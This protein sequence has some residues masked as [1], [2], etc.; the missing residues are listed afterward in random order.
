MAPDAEWP[1][2]TRVPYNRRDALIYATGI[3]LG[4]QE[5]ELKFVYELHPDFCIVPTLFVPFIFWAAPGQSSVMDQFKDDIQARVPGLPERIS[6]GQDVHYEQSI[7]FHRPFPVSGTL[8]VQAKTVGAFQG[9]KG[10]VMEFQQRIIDAETGIVYATMEGSS[11]RLQ[12]FS[13]ALKPR[14]KHP[15]YDRPPPPGP[16]TFVDRFKTFKYLHTLYGQVAPPDQNVIH[17]I[18]S[19]AVKFGYKRLILHGTLNFSLAV[20]AV[21]RHCCGN[22]PSRLVSFACRFSKPVYPENTC[23]TSIWKAGSEGGNDLYRFTMAC[24]EEAVVGKDGTV[25]EHVAL[26]GGWAVVRPA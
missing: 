20:K 21:V 22:D 17:I 14:P 4:A 23:V 19:E 24:E 25:K 2:E 11:V 13:H 12:A 5:D 26:Q 3:G 1:C 16:P 6:R 8:R 7:T 9:S 10:A 15:I 18:D